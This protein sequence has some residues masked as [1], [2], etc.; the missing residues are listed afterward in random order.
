MHTVQRLVCHN[1]L[2]GYVGALDG[3]DVVVSLLCQGMFLLF[4]EQKMIAHLL[5]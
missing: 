5:H 1:L 2:C 3:L 4:E